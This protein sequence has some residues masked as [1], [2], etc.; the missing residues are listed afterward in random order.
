[1]TKDISEILPKYAEQLTAQITPNKSASVIY[2]PPCTLQHGQKIRGN[3]EEL[4]GKIGIQVNLCADSHLCCGSAGTYSILQA[5]LSNQLRDQKVS[6]L[7][8]AGSTYQATEIVS[9]NVGCISHLQNDS[10]P[11]RHWIEI[12]DDLLLA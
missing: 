7:V 6:Q 12:I 4:L 11:V 10:L 2:H 8:Q 1:M 9:G 5:N 3:V